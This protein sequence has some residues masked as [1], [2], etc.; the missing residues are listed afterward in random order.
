MDNQQVS[1][2]E[3]LKILAFNAKFGDG[4]F[5]KHPTCVNYKL[6]FMSTNKELLKAKMSIYPEIFPSGISTYRKAGIVKGVTDNAKELFRLTSLVHPLFTEYKHLSKEELLPQLTKFDFGL[7]YLD[8][9]CCIRRK[10]HFNYRFFLCIGDTC[11]SEDLTQVFFSKIKELFPNEKTYGTV[12]KN[13]SKATQNNKNWVIPVPIAK[14]IMNEVETFF[15]IDK[16]FPYRKTSETIR[17]E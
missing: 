16:K 14:K 2:I 13:N 5:W 8:D 17:K 10:P 15:I 9:G 7:W 1:S 6:I 3:K 4:Y 12:K 11:V